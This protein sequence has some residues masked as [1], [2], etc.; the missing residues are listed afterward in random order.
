[1]VVQVLGKKSDDVLKP[2]LFLQSKD[3]Y[4]CFGLLVEIVVV[5]S[6]VRI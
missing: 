3:L 6:F 2:I 5:I 1:M 4:D